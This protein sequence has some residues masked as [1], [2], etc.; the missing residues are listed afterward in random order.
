MFWFSLILLLFIVAR[1]FHV[2]IGEKRRLAA[3]AKT[4]RGGV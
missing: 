4:L 1:E 2:L 3:M